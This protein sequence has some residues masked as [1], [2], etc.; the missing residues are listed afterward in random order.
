MHTTLLNKTT[1]NNISME[2]KLYPDKDKIPEDASNS[3][4]KAKPPYSYVA[5]IA[6]AIQNSAMKRAT[7][8]EIYNFIA[9]KFPY[10]EQN[11]K[12]WQNSIRHNLSLNEC[13]IKVPREGA[14]DR[15]GN[16]WTLDPNYEDMFENGNYRR[17]RRMKRPYRNISQFSTPHSLTDTFKSKATL[18]QIPSPSIYQYNSSLL[19]CS[20]Q[21]MATQASHSNVCNSRM[22][23]SK[24]CMMYSPQTN[25]VAS[26]SYGNK[27]NID[28][29][30]ENIPIDC[31]KIFDGH[32][33]ASWEA[34]AYYQSIKREAPF[35]LSTGLTNYQNSYLSQQ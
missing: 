14:G 25:L 35:E 21:W 10:F 3:T 13:F 17:R 29:V 8:N 15:K 20:S 12:G 31:S 32:A 9:L 1:T 30:H 4:L 16:Y 26:N 22:I 33:V 5:L 7:L 2:S 27:L 18:H 19:A 24:N 6:M 23:N 11:K 28:F 34:E